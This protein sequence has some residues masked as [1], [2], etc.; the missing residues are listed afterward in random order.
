M[1]RE[2]EG[3]LKGMASDWPGWKKN[4]FVAYVSEGR[5]KRN[6]EMEFLTDSR[7]GVI[8]G[9]FFALTCISP[10]GML[11]GMLES[12]RMSGRWGMQSTA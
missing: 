10:E 11:A 12:C 7:Q 6:K 8:L 9:V 5:Q 2:L 3:K 4:L 1:R